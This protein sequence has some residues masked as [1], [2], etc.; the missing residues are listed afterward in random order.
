MNRKRSPSTAVSEGDSRVAIYYF[1]V[2]DGSGIA[3]DLGM[4]LSSLTDAKC[5]AVR[6]AGRL[7]CDHA[8]K[9]WHSGDWAMTVTDEKG[10]ALF[11][12]RL[13][14]TEAPAILG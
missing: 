5:E 8:G 11:T 9:F 10:L 13:S 14:G 1:Q 6:Y 12:L 2:D 4:E 3:D 7:I